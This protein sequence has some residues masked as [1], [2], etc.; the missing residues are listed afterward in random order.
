MISGYPKPVGLSF[1]V[2]C[3]VMQADISLIHKACLA[4]VDVSTLDLLLSIL[5]ETNHN[6]NTKNK[7]SYWHALTGLS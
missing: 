3:V 6:I 5:S 4:S 7:V 1:H 2:L